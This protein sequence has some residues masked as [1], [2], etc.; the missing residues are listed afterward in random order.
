MKRRTMIIWTLVGTFLSLAI[1][2]LSYF[3]IIRYFTLHMSSTDGFTEGYSK[4]PKASDTR[5]VVSFAAK[6]DDIDMLKPMLNSLLDQTVKVDQIG[7]V[8]PL[9]NEIDLPDYLKKVVNVF[10]AGRDYGQGDS[11]YPY[12]TKG[13]GV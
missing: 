9:H 1:I 13:E 11:T 7:M 2:L 12:P 5:V 8:L 4:L 10:P 3:G 6:A